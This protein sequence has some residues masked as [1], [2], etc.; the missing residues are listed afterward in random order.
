MKYLCVFIP[1]LAGIEILTLICMCVMSV[2]L[3][4][5]IIKHAPM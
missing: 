5:D 1:M 4:V 3:L 2:M